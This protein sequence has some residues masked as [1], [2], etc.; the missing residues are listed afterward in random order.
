M[1]DPD[2]SGLVYDIPGWSSDTAAFDSGVETGWTPTDG[3]Y[4]AFLMSGD[5]FSLAVDGL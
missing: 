3:N 4:T 1:H 2:W 5:S